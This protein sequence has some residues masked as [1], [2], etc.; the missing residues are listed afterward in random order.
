MS[1]VKVG[2]ERDRP[3]TPAAS[4]VVAGEG[5]LPGWRPAA[6][7]ASPQADGEG[8]PALHGHQALDYI[9]H[10]FLGG[11][12]WGAPKK[13]SRGPSGRRGARAFPGPGMTWGEAGRG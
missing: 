2:R 7:R 13:S 9:A 12:E 11:A 3:R 4:G 5:P 1:S 10:F 6:I 8:F